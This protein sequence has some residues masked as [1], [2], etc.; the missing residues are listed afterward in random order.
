MINMRKI[1][2]L[3]V[4]IVLSAATVSAQPVIER[5]PLLQIASDMSSDLLGMRVSAGR[6][7]IANAAGNYV[8]FDLETREAFKG[9]AK[10][11]KI[12]DFDV[13]LGQLVFIDAEGRL[14]GRFNS[15]WPDRAYDGCRVDAADQGLLVSGGDKAFFLGKTATYAVEIG[16][17]DFVLP[18]AN[19]FIWSLSS[20]KGGNWGAD[21][22]DCLGNLMK[23]VYS[24]SAEFIPTGI[25]VGPAGS[26]GE[27]LV[28][29][30]ENNARKLALI[31][32]NGRMFWKIDGPE[33]TGPRDIAFDDQGNLLVIERKGS[34]LWL[35]RWV[36]TFP[37]G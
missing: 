2:S 32:N 30:N 14:G 1:L 8:R 22:Y 11:N 20:K 17:L 23:E 5:E 16:S 6:V 34:E 25:E 12:I 24:F 29:Y 4:V 21:L 10:S 31:G 3:I 37:E 33:K 26:E 9:K 18:V 13:I 15:L 27:L 35:N 19:G 7:F 36:I 28:S